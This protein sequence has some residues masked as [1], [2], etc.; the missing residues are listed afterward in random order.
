MMNKFDL[1]PLTGWHWALGR[2]ASHR[3]PSLFPPG[4]GSADLDLLLHKALQPG[5]RPLLKR[6]LSVHPYGFV[7]AAAPGL[8]LPL[9]IAISGPA[10]PGPDPRLAGR[11]PAMP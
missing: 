4:M 5:L 11:P 2:L 6:G 3:P 1:S 7:T 8:T 9:A 10:R